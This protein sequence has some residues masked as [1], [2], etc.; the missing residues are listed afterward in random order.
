[1]SGVIRIQGC[2]HPYADSSGWFQNE[3]TLRTRVLI[4]GEEA[5]CLQASRTGEWSDQSVD[6][7]PYIGTISANKG[8]KIQVQ[9]RVTD[10][11]IKLEGD[12]VFDNPVSASV[13]L[14]K[15]SILD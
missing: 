3:E 12:T 5:R 7:L 8:S 6:I 10:T 4:D 11:D 1:M 13:N 14:E 15:I 2:I 9:W